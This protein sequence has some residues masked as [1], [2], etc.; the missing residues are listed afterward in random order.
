VPVCPERLRSICGERVTARELAGRL[1]K[2]ADIYAGMGGGVTF[3]GGEPLMQPEFLL[4]TMRLLPGVHKAVETCGY[5]AQDVFRAVMRTADL[6][7][8]DVKAVDPRTHLA[9]TGVSNSGILR[10]LALLA[11][12]DAPFVVR[13]PLIPGVSDTRDNFR[14]TAR[15]LQGAKRLQYVEL[16]PYNRMAGAKYGWLGL[17]YRPAFDT[18]SPVRDGRDILRDYGIEG[19]LM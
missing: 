4:E 15:L 2:N 8:M 5:A 18:E 12:G 3:S 10:N 19:R 16:L 1:L 9:Y 7:M 6:V 17:R 11:A 14:E 13:I